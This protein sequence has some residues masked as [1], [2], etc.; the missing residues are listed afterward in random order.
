MALAVAI[1]FER[2]VEL[3][4]YPDV[5][6]NGSDA[7]A[8]QAIFVPPLPVPP[9]PVPVLPPALAPPPPVPIVPP[10]PLPPNGVKL[11]PDPRLPPFPFPPDGL[12]LPPFALPPFPLLDDP[13]APVVLR[14]GGAQPSATETAL[15]NTKARNRWYCMIRLLLSFEGPGSG[16][17]S[18]SVGAYPLLVTPKSD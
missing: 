5:Y 13:P 14:A 15:T 6:G 2:C 7:D 1:A 17:R 11:P 10:P 8:P 16:R 3:A 18:A 12:P 9:P 4:V